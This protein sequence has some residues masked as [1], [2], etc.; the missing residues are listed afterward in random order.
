M[1]TLQDWAFFCDG[2][3]DEYSFLGIKEN[4]TIALSF[5]RIFAK[6]LNTFYAVAIS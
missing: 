2:S 3:L 6:H 5:L 4:V 1:V